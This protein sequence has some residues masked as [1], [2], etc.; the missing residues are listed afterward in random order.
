MPGRGQ[1]LPL[2]QDSPLL[3]SC[4]K[5]GLGIEK[6]QCRDFPGGPAAKTKL[7]SS[8]IGGTG[9]IPGWRIK[10][11][12]AGC[13]PQKISM[14]VVIVTQLCKYIKVTELCKYSKRIITQFLKILTKKRK[15]HILALECPAR[16]IHLL[17]ALSLPFAQGQA[18]R[19]RRHLRVGL[20]TSEADPGASWDLG[21]RAGCVEPE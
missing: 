17:P 2:L 5:V 6:K 14:S 11:L 8:N 7:S 21:Q 20:K 4:L 1:Q 13:S 18:V 3:H 19:Q 16:T 15:P 12:C 9:S 10:V